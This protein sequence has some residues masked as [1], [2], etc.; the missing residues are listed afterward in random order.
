[1]DNQLSFV[2]HDS[3][4]DQL[5]RKIHFKHKVIVGTKIDKQ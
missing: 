5:C 1:M 3:L 4:I 2:F